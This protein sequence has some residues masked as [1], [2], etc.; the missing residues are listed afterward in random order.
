MRSILT[1]TLTPA[2]IFSFP[3]SKSQSLDCSLTR[4]V[5]GL[6]FL[7]LPPT[8][9]SDTPNSYLESFGQSAR[10]DG[11]E[12]LEWGLSGAAS[13]LGFPGLVLSNVLEHAVV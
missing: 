10:L 3:I 11:Q 12:S 7:G 9:A 8:S 5:K 6:K 4:R 1:T 2:P 13:H